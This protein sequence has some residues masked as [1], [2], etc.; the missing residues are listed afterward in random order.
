[1]C[2]PF[3]IILEPNSSQLEMVKSLDSSW[4]NSEQWGFWSLTKVD[5]HVFRLLRVYCHLVIVRPCTHTVQYTL[6]IADAN[7]LYARVHCAILGILTFTYVS[8]KFVFNIFDK[9][10]KRIGEMTDLWGTAAG[11][12]AVN[13][14]SSLI[15]TCW[16]LPS[17][18]LF[19][20]KQRYIVVPMLSSLLKG[21][22][23]KCPY[24]GYSH[25]I[26][27]PEGSFQGNRPESKANSHSCIIVETYQG[28]FLQKSRKGSDC[29]IWWQ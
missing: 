25:V 24:D 16:V 3:K 15:L 7:G 26:C 19:N 20:H 18:K 5:P 21:I 13:N 10:V 11:Q 17:R 28:M 2:V 14:C 22:E 6:R 27:E 12:R 9:N 4:S 23:S 8:F 1:M 29:K